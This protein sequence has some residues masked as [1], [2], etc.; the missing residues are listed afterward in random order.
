M[1]DEPVRC[2]EWARRQ[3]I[4][5]IGTAGTYEGYL[6]V[7]WPG[8]WPR[9]AGDVEE[10]RPLAGRL[11]EDRIRLQL[12]QDGS[13]VDGKRPDLHH[14]VLYASDGDGWFRRYQRTA[15]T[16]RRADVVAAAAALLEGAT[17]DGDVGGDRGDVLICAHGSRDTC[18]GSLGTKLLAAVARDPQCSAGQFR[19]WRTSHTG[20]H[21]FAP[22]AIVLPW[23]M[24]LGFLNPDVLR[25]ILAREADVGEVVAH[26]R[27]CSGLSSPEAQILDR[28]VFEEIGWTWLDHRRRAELS[29][30]GSVR[31]DAVSPE[32]TARSWEGIV[33]AGRELP[34]P[35]C[36]SPLAST[37]K[38]EIELQLGAYREVT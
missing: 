8:P 22:T 19:L 16:A 17:G 23:G 12:V 36:R 38:F 10:L 27:G 25:R 32:G 29:A 37:T 33:V 34:V 1:S 24:S 14:V 3:Q 13:A 28:V 31:L 18:C 6:L 11:A 21:R 2:A 15:T 30:G 4:R 26:L 20:G 7:E 5:P 35:I 9:D